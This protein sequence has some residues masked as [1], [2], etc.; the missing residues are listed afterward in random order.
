MFESQIERDRPI[1][2]VV[3]DDHALL[4]ELVDDLDAGVIPVRARRVGP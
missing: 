4:A 3:V 1:T 2:V